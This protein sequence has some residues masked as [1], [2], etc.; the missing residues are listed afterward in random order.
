MWNSTEEIYPFLFISDSDWTVDV[1]LEVPEGYQI[2]DPGAC[3]QTLISNETK[4]VEFKVA[5]IGSPEKFDALVKMTAT[6]KGKKTKVDLKVN[7][8]NKKIK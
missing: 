3:T 2:V 6:H 7:S 8:I 4:V 5:D 1:C